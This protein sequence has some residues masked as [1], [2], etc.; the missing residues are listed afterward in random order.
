MEQ[1][2]K[3]IQRKI[4]VTETGFWRRRVRRTFTGKIPDCKNWRRG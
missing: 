4:L 1:I 2:N 3:D